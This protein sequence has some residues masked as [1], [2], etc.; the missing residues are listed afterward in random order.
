MSSIELSRTAVPILGLLTWRPMAGYEIRSEIE[1]SLG[2]FWS[3][4]FGQLYPQLRALEEAGLI[5]EAKV[6]AADPRNKRIFKITAAGRKALRAWISQAPESRPPRNELLLKLFFATEGDA[7]DV[8]AHL[9]S[10]R[11]AASERLAKYRR[12]RRELLAED[13]NG[14][15]RRDYWLMTLDLG[16]SQIESLVKWCDSCLSKIDDR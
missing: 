1:S 15:P 12:I 5:V 11:Q 4:S 13:D 9:R 10:H 2:N 16:I 7:E 6:G 14:D 3:E 8:A